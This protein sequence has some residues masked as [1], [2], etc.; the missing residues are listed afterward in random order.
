MNMCDMPTKTRDGDQEARERALAVGRRISALRTREGESQAQLGHRLAVDYRTA[1]R[2]EQGGNNRTIAFRGSSGQRNVARLEVGELSWSAP[3]KGSRFVGPGCELLLT[4]EQSYGE[5][6]GY[7]SRGIY[8]PD[9]T[10]I[11]APLPPAGDSLEGR[12]RSDPTISEGK[13][14]A[15]LSILASEL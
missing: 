10:R 4:I 7:L 6:E 12:I 14:I 3:G 1:T 2:I 8:Y 13:R 15:L 5:D 11:P 9:P